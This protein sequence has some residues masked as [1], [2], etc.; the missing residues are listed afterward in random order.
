MSKMITD[1]ESLKLTVDGQGI[2]WYIQGEGMP[3]SSGLDAW[4]FL[5]SQ[6]LQDAEHIRMVGSAVNA[7]LL[8]QLY[9]RKLKGDFQSVQVC[10]PMCCDTGDERKDPE[11]V[12]Y[13]MRVTKSWW[14]A[15]VW[16]TRL[17]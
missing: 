8:Q 1:S 7:D 3:H 13:R 6:L 12:L 17:S 5:K 2:V 16:F 11:L 15:R 9:E 10:S 14:L 4:S